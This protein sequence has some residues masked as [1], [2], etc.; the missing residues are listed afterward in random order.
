VHLILI[1]AVAEEGSV[2]ERVTLRSVKPNG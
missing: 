2:G 1:V